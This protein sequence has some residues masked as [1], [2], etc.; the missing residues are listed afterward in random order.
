MSFRCLGE[1]TPGCDPDNPLG[2]LVVANGNLDFASNYMPST[3][4]ATVPWPTSRRRRRRR[5]RRRPRRRRR[6]RRMPPAQTPSPP[7]PQC[8]QNVYAWADNHRITD[9]GRSVRLHQ[10]RRPRI[11]QCPRFNTAEEAA[12][13]ATAITD[14]DT[15]EV[16]NSGI[17]VLPQLQRQLDAGTFEQSTSANKHVSV[18]RDC[19]TYLGPIP[20]EDTTC[21]AEGTIQYNADGVNPSTMEE[22]MA[23]CDADVYCAGIHD[24][25]YDNR[26]WRTCPHMAF[27]NAANDNSQAYI[28]P[29]PPQCW[30]NAYTFADDYK[31][32][33]CT[34]FTRCR[35]RLRRRQI[36]CSVA[37]YQEA[38]QN[39][40]ALTD[41]DAVMFKNPDNGPTYVFAGYY[42]CGGNFNFAP[43]TDG[44]ARYFPSVRRDC[45]SYL[46][47]LDYDN[48]GDGCTVENHEAIAK[49]ARDADDACMGIYDFNGDGAW[50]WCRS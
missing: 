12:A 2:T 35:A 25:N 31:L 40:D 47:A 30:Q 34:R 26:W 15:V 19:T 42:R 39:C 36:G 5:R 11:F 1:A 16:S 21:N 13:G 23:A 38:Q 22:A 32:T 44:S 24:Y 17:G 9:L 20:V 4:G 8:W 37:S 27:T 6:H 33:G 10:R 50:R 14:C 49:A 28:K 45:T 48:A 46:G 7:P 41:C 43:D 3:G 18:R 29:Q